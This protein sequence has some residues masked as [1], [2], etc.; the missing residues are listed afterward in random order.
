VDGGRGSGSGSK[1][2]SAVLLLSADNTL[3]NLLSNPQW[4]A[5][6]NLLGGASHLHRAERHGRLSYHGFG[7]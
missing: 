6:R 3:Q 1:H 2:R 5:L 4:D 7:R